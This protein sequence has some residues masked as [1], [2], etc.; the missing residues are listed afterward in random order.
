MVRPKL[1]LAMT[2]I[3]AL[4]G[5]A[6]TADHGDES[7][8]G[9]TSTSSASTITYSEQF[10]S[11][12]PTGWAVHNG[13]TWTAFSNSSDTEHPNSLKGVGKADPGFSSLVGLQ[14]Y[15]DFEATMKFRIEDGVEQQAAGIVVHFYDDGNYQIIRYS[16]NEN[17]W[18][19]FT[20]VD[21]TRTKQPDATLEAQTHPDFHQW[22]DLRVESKEGVITVHDGT[23]KV[24]EYRLSASDIDFGGIG[25][26][27]RGDATA[28]F[29]DL[30]VDP[31]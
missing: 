29:D 2:L 5:C 3:A 8:S 21:G 13:G 25:P 20:F 12:M 28:L 23:T 1:L 4:S 9:T 19:L 18:H 26:F 14:S 6:D 11:G 16:I 22:I 31:L 30:T 10:E 27:V 24:I 17:S 15:T 7:T